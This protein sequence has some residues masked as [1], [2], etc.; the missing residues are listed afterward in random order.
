L[1]QSCRHCEV[2]TDLEGK[3]INWS[4]LLFSAAWT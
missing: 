4:F 2:E 1:P 3:L